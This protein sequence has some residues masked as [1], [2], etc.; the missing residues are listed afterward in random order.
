MG[1]ELNHTQSMANVWCGFANWKVG[2]GKFMC[3]TKNK[4]KCAAKKAFWLEA[5]APIAR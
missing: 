3:G 5:P 4:Q 1:T 2:V